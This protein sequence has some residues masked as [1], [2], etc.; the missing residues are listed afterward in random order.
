MLKMHFREIAHLKTKK[1]QHNASLF[2]NLTR[3]VYIG[4]VA[5]Q[6]SFLAFLMR[7]PLNQQR[8]V[9]LQ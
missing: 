6:Y 4:E 9:Q 1:G 5:S 3:Y 7:Q 2:N 8:L